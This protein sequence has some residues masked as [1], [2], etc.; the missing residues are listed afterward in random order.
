MGLSFCGGSFAGSFAR[1]RKVAEQDNS[2]GKKWQPCI[3]P[4]GQVAPKYRALG[5]VAPK[6]RAGNT[7]G[8]GPI[9]LPS[10]GGRANQNVGKSGPQGILK[11]LPQL[12]R[13]RGV[14]PRKADCFDIPCIPSYK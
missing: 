10:A 4:L 3:G 9:C 14:R 1:C 6:Y 2:F 13:F 12:M 8:S 5:Q 7:F 11:Q